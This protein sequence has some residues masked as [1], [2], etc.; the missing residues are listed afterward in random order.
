VIVQCARCGCEYDAGHLAAGSAVAC[1]CGDLL[2]VPAAD[3]LEHPEVIEQFVERWA[4][5]SDTTADALAVDG[6]WE[7][8]AGSA[9]VRIEHDAE[10][11][12]LTIRSSVMTLP[13]DAKRRAAM[14]EKLLRLNYQQT[15]EARF[16]IDADEVIIT[17]TRPTLGL[18]YHEFPWRWSRS[19][20]RP[21]TTT[22][23]CGVSLA[24]RRR[25]RRLIWRGTRRRAG[26]TR[27]TAS[28]TQVPAS[29][30]RFRE[31]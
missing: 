23:S 24:G 3:D 27:E 12:A 2:C 19:R 16:A 1:Q 15:G 10:D 30:L 17:F 9:E 13:A 28:G 6:G 26:E 5:S 21:M 25:R 14:M 18:D 31:L 22:T 7:F 20:R 29:R 8:L 4:K 11:A